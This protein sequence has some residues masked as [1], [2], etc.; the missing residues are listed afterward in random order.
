MSISF[1]RF[2][3][4]LGCSIRQYLP[5]HQ[6]YLTTTQVAIGTEVSSFEVGTILCCR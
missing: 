2:G 3:A 1:P 5:D 4:L 6:P